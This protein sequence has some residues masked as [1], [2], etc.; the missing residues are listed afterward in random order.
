[1]NNIDKGFFEYFTHSLEYKIM[2][3]YLFLGVVFTQTLSSNDYITN[4]IDIL[5][6]KIFVSIF[7]YPSFL[8]LYYIFYNY[9]N[10][11]TALLLRIKNRNNYKKHNLINIIFN[12]LF[13]YIN[14]LLLI[15]IVTNLEGKIF[16][17][18]QM[19]YGVNN[20]IMLIIVAVKNVLNL[21]ILGLLCNFLKLKY[22]FRFSSILIFFYLIVSSLGARLYTGVFLIDMFNPGIHSCGYNYVD[23]IDML[24][25]MS[26]IYYIVLIPVLIYAIGIETKKVLIGVN[27]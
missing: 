1:M 9:S 18:N 21:I 7:L 19:L 4:I 22:S 14:V 3:V 24:I 20:Y 6:D 2:L 11:N 27:I 23:S 17:V 8:A 5:S 16:K 10:N 26:I 13:L 12:T 15:I 25:K